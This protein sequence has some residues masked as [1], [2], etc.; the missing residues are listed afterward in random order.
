MINRIKKYIDNKI[1]NY[2]ESNDDLYR[3]LV[4]DYVKGHTIYK[5]IEIKNSVIGKLDIH[6]CLLLDGILV[7]HNRFHPE[8]VNADEFIINERGVT[9]IERK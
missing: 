9:R 4:K 8:V 7:E 2:V 6:D 3:S 5:K 1:Y